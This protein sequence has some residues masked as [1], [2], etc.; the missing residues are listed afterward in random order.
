M[1]ITEITES[2]TGRKVKN[3]SSEATLQAQGHGS[4]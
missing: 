3:I 2:A 1:S 4:K